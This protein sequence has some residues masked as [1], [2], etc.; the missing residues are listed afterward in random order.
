MAPIEEAVAAA[1]VGDIVACEAA[2]RRCNFSFD[3]VVGLLPAALFGG[4][5]DVVR[6]IVNRCG[7]HIGHDDYTD[8]TVAYFKSWIYSKDLDDAFAAL[9]E[10]WP[11][12]LPTPPWDAARAAACRRAGRMTTAFAASLNEWSASI[13]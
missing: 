11:V 5:A 6:L 4:N 13:D 2:I 7:G 3:P 9:L 10:G 12:D 1:E 8:A